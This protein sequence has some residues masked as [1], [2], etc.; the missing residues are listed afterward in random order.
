MWEE[1]EVRITQGWGARRRDLDFLL[2]V[3]E[4]LEFLKQGSNKIQL[5]FQNDPFG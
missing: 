5:A 1:A 2:C 4:S 3:L